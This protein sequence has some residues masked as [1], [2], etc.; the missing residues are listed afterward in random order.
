MLTRKGMERSWRHQLQYGGGGGA[1]FG[2]SD[3]TRLRP[4]TISLPAL[5]KKKKRKKKEAIKLAKK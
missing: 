1:C 2:T 5:K 4:E 3:P